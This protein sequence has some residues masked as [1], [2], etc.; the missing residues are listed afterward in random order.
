MYEHRYSVRDKTAIGISMA[1]SDSVSKTASRPTTNTKKI[2]RL[3]SHSELHLDIKPSSSAKVK[4]DGTRYLTRSASITEQ[5]PSK[6]SKPR[7]NV[8]R[9]RLGYG[10]T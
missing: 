5:N 7:S 8:D 9:R 3:T 1:Q 4:V 6:Q 2:T 10:K